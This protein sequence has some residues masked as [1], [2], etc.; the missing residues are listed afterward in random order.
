MKRSS[1]IALVLMGAT[2]LGATSYAMAPRT[3]CVPPGQQRPAVAAGTPARPGQSLQ[4][5]CRERRWGG[6]SH[7]SG[8][9][10]WGSRSSG[11]MWGRSAS[12]SSAGLAPTSPST[13]RAITNP[14]ASGILSSSSGSSVARGGFG[15]TGHGFSVAS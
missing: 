4:P 10:T 12:S 1:Q 13:M 8:S 14:S 5:E 9:S 3:D 2:S 7:S 15:S 6:S 11:W